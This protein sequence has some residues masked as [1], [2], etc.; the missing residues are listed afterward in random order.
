MQPNME[1][2]AWIL[3]L[4]TF[5]FLAILGAVALWALS[6]SARSGTD[7]FGMVG[8][9]LGWLLVAAVVWKLAQ[10]PEDFWTRVQERLVQQLPTAP[11]RPSQAPPSDSPSDQPPPKAEPSGEQ[12]P[13]GDS[14]GKP[15]APLPSWTRQEKWRFEQG[16]QG[17]VLRRAVHTQFFSAEELPRAQ[18]ELRLRVCTQLALLAQQQFRLDDEKTQH[19]TQHLNQWPRTEELFLKETFQEVRHF[20]PPTG[21]MYRLHALLEVHQQDLHRLDQLV[22]ELRARE[23][24]SRVVWALG[25]IWVALGLVLVGL[26]IDQG[27]RGRFRRWLQVGVG[28]SI[29]GWGALVLWAL[30]L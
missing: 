3:V 13:W 20:E 14:Q 24:A 18:Q 30:G 10:F 27:T 6:R 12:P 9:T 7:G 26:K 17:W 8:R 2:A 28:A 16:Q 29:L 22:Q 19:L 5:V 1:I 25:G 11:E 4:A 23:A 21:T 15:S